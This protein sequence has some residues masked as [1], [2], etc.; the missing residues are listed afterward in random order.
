MSD[1]GTVLRCVNDAA[2]EGDDNHASW[3]CRIDIVGLSF[4]NINALEN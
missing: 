2:W 1:S 4:S 3:T